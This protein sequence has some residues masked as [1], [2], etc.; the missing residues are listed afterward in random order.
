MLTKIFFKKFHDAY[1][2]SECTSVGI[3]AHAHVLYFRIKRDTQNQL[4]GPLSRYMLVTSLK[5]LELIHQT[6]SYLEAHMVL[7][8]CTNSG[9]QDHFSNRSTNEARHE[10]CVSM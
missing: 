7:S 8:A 2:P 5:S 1:Y 4:L 6:V 10:S 3:Y 9:Y